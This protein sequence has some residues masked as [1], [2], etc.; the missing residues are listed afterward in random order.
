MNLRWLAIVAILSAAVPAAAQ[1]AQEKQ[2]LQTKK[3]KVSYGIG[4]DAGKSFRNQKLDIDIELMIKGLRDAYSGNELLIPETEIRAVL[5]AFQK[6]L[7]EQRAAETKM[8]AE[9]N[10]KEGEAFLAKNKTMEGVVTTK[11]GLQYKII[12]AGDGPKPKKESTVEVNYRGILINGTEFDSSYKRGKPVSF[13]VDGVIP[14][15]QEALQLMPVG[16]KW[17]LSVPPDLAYG[18]RG[19]GNQIGP[20]SVLIFEVELLAIKPPAEAGSPAKPSPPKPEQ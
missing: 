18:T 4:V 6:E 16:S 12:Q 8:A 5:T 15:W 1:E 3:E 14:G 10:K 13:R 2:A 7:V 17:Q 20:N 11:S 19:V 9:K